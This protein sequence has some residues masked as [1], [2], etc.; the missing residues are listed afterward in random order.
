MVDRATLAAGLDPG[1]ASVIKACDA[2]LQ[3]KFP[4]RLRDTIEVFTG[5]W[6]VHSTHR[7]PAKGGL[8]F[9]LQVSQDETE[10]LSALM[11]YKCAIADIPFG[12]AKGGLVIDPSK[13]Q[14]DELAEITRRFARELARRDLLNP[15]TNVPAPDMGTSSREMAWIA[16]TYKTLFPEDVNQDACVTGKPVSRGG[17]PGRTDAVGKGVQFALQEFFRH[18][19]E[20]EKAGLSDGLSGQRVV[21]QG[22]GNVGYHTAKYL[23][24]EDKVKVIAIIERDGVVFDEDGLNVHD[25]RQHFAENGVLK[26]FQK[27]E[28][29]PQGSEALE[30]ECDILIP[31]ALESQIHAGNAMN[32]QASLIVEAAN[33]PVTYEADEILQRRGIVMLP[34]IYV[35]AGGVTVSYFEWA[36]NISHM[37]FGRLQRRYEELRAT[38]YLAAL[39]KMTGREAPRD[40][41][42][43]IV[44][45]A[46][47]LDLVRSGLDDTMRAA[48]LDIREVMKRNDNIQDYRTAAY[49][50]A[51]QKLA[52][53]YYDLGLVNTP[54]E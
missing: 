48:F 34:D 4:V 7:L 3:F 39:E 26:G 29:S 20:M 13:Y 30:M 52:R 2:V 24:E 11:S 5:W 53:S 12:G 28:Y 1:T 17:I 10:A 14:I 32:I 47:E 27:A 37:R 35:N 51:I 8:R 41:R 22:L 9:T 18:P 31:A 50:I 16:D 36:R 44:R 23:S 38:T 42:T 19:E 6:A 54:E 15:A 21:I 25:I 49:V 46:S 45:G 33:G 40:L 43:E